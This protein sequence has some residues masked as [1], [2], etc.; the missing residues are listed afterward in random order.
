MTWWHHDIRLRYR[1]RGC[2]RVITS[3]LYLVFKRTEPIF[4]SGSEAA[5]LTD[6]SLSDETGNTPEHTLSPETFQE[7]HRTHTVDSYSYSLKGTVHMFPVESVLHVLKEHF[8]GF[9]VWWL[10]H[11]VCSWSWC[12]CVG[13]QD[14]KTSSLDR[15]WGPW[16]VLWAASGVQ[17]SDEEKFLPTVWPH[18][19]WIM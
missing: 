6:F 15:V 1:H 3:S 14:S 5:E 2:Y 18:Q 17:V 4:S 11:R 7:Q 16:G 9:T 13:V 19:T 12:G 10:Q 8:T